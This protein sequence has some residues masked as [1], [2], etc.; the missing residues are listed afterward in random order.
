MEILLPFPKLQII[1]S[2][3]EFITRKI[4]CWKTVGN[5][6]SY[7]DFNGRPPAVRY[8]TLLCANM[9]ATLTYKIRHQGRRTYKIQFG[10]KCT[11]VLSLLLIV[12]ISF[13]PF[14][15]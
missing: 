12:K 4:K 13:Y 7:S 8:I 15:T 9:A 1:K 6:A 2:H 14:S 11:C 10:Y 3:L 5:S